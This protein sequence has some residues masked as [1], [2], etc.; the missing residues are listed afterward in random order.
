MLSANAGEKTKRCENQ[1]HV[2]AEVPSEAESYRDGATEAD[3]G[4]PALEFDAFLIATVSAGP[5]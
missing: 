1:G 2:H 5:L 3:A 4:D